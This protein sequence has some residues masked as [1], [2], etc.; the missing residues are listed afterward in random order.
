MKIISPSPYSVR[1]RVTEDYLKRNEEF[2]LEKKE[3]G[4]YPTIALTTR[5]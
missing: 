1:Y 5:R 4:T 3:K 2:S